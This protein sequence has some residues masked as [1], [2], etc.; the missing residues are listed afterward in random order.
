MY[1][2]FLAAVVLAAAG[3]AFATTTIRSAGTGRTIEEA[4]TDAFRKAVEVH[5]GTAIVSNFEV[6]KQEIIRNEILA[7][8]AGYVENFKIVS[9]HQLDGRVEIVVDVTVSSSKIHKRILSDSRTDGQFNGASAGA[10]VQTWL[11]SKN[12][13]DGLVAATF[14]NWP[15]TGFNIHT[16]LTNLKVDAYRNPYIEV[17]YKISYNRNWLDAFKEALQLTGDPP[18]SR[19]S[20]EGL[21]IFL[22]NPNAVWAT[23]RWNAYAYNDYTSLGKIRGLF[24]K[25]MPAIRTSLLSGGVVVSSACTPF[26][27]ANF[28]NSETH[29]AGTSAIKIYSTA[30]IDDKTTLRLP[31]NINQMYTVTDIRVEVVR[32]SRCRNN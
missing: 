30:V 12:D 23:N 19:G 24:Q 3:T 8:S 10:G 21:V 9:L 5:I 4:R 14:S 17:N 26:P 22:D 31:K 16:T 32:I 13:G 7:Y 11:K 27:I 2:L 15:E 28:Y 6:S 1:K 20:P 25:N 29:A 18:P